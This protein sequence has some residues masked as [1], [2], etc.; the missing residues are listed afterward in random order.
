MKAGSNRMPFNFWRKPKIDE[1]KL[2]ALI[3]RFD[4]DF[5]FKEIQKNE[6]SSAFIEITGSFLSL[7]AC[8]SLIFFEEQF[9]IRNAF[10]QQRDVIAYE[11]LAYV[12]G[13]I[14]RDL[15]LRATQNKDMYDM[16]D[17]E[18]ER[19]ENSNQPTTSDEYL[20]SAI[21]T[22]KMINKT[23]GWSVD[24][25]MFGEKA[26]LH[27]GNYGNKNAA[28]KFLTAISEIGQSVVPMKNYATKAGLP[29]FGLEGLE[30]LPAISTFVQKMPA[31]YADAF[32][33]ILDQHV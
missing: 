25:D 10:Q 28:E 11:S 6:G 23:T 8:R 17:D 32:E 14:H 9:F 31:V 13:E 33:K 20:R 22:S 26:V 12:V 19:F 27:Y 29:I 5:T 1:D 21:F 18:F 7:C 30:L 4:S 3:Q 15:A 2:L 24:A 16:D